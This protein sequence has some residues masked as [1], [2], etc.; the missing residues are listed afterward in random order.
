MRVDCRQSGLLWLGRLF[1]HLHDFGVVSILL[2]RVLI[3]DQ[4]VRILQDLTVRLVFEVCEVLFLSWLRLCLISLQLNLSK[5]L[6]L[7]RGWLGQCRVLGHHFLVHPDPL[8]DKHWEYDGF[9]KCK[10]NADGLATWPL[11][12]D[13]VLDL[14]L[15]YVECDVKSWPTAAPVACQALEVS[16]VIAIVVSA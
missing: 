14:P 11:F 15:D 6:D 8:E 12:Q 16:V 1:W 10:D 3:V 5:V 7:A 13:W 9:N 4:A 2:D